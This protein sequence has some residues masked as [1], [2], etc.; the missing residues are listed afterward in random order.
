MMAEGTWPPEAAEL[1]EWTRRRQVESLRNPK[2]QNDFRAACFCA[3]TVFGR[4]TFVFSAA[5]VA[6]MWRLC[7]A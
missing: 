4:I 2:Y 1:G 3:K 6:L 7:G 5:L